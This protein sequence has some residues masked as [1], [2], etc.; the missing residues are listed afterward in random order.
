MAAQ[1]KSTQ[2]D[3]LVVMATQWR[4]S[5]LGVAGDPNAR[6]PHLDA[7]ARQ[8]VYLRQAVT[9]HP[10]GVFARAAFLTGKSCPA[11]GVRDYFDPLPSRSETLARAFARS[12]YQSAFFGKWQLYRR[13]PAAPVVGEA[14]ARIVVPEDCRGGFDYWEGFESGFLLN[15]P[16]L[17]GTDLPEP[18][19]F[20][21]YQS[22]VL[23]E[24]MVEF[25]G[26]RDEAKPLF[27]WL[28]LDAPHPPYASPASGIDRYP[29]EGL[30][31]LG[32]TTLD[33][34]QRRIALRELSG[35]YAHVEA[36]D[37]SI[38]RLIATLKERGQWENTV[39]VFTSAHGDMHGSHGHFRK[40]WPHEQ[41]V[42]VPLMVSWPQALPARCD[43][44]TLISLLDLG[45]TLLG[46]SG[47]DSSWKAEGLDLSDCLK[48]GA[49]G[50]IQQ[51]LSMPS[52]PPF[53]KQ[54]PY[55]WR[56]HRNEERTTVFP[57][58]AKSFVIHHLDEDRWENA[59]LR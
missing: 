20:S 55:P 11:N 14:H 21:G 9:P 7:L 57:E 58:G 38:A 19:R 29:E 25:L 48:G 34:E 37:R 42:R 35:Y 22:D 16:L 4:G 26:R 1:T 52:V 47:A 3:V 15:D 27:A 39:F 31:L 12:G 28:S 30:R 36:T 56:A 51:E 43:D 50:P 45:P 59:E 46:L 24:R 18:T 13:D 17:H 44:R 53:E 8:S 32:E 23:V 41:S 2:P 33:P 49:A 6:T 40:G 10:F 54:C 5:A